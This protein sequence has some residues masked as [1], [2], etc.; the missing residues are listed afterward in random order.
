MIDD[1]CEEFDVQNEQK[2]NMQ[3]FKTIVNNLIEDHTDEISRL[4]A[5]EKKEEE[6]APETKN[7]LD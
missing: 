7:K 6:Q 3:G 5:P 2:N 1:I 4:H